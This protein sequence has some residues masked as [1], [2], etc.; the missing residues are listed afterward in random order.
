MPR[1]PNTPE[2]FWSKVNQTDTCWEW[3]GKSKPDGYVQFHLGG[4]FQYIHRIA[5]ELTH[6]PIGGGLFVLHKCDNRLCCN[7]AHLFLGTHQDNMDDMKN[8][9]RQAQG[10]THSRRIHEV[11]ARGERNG[12]SKLTIDDVREIRRLASSGMR[13]TDIARQFGVHK[14][15]VY[16]IVDQITWRHT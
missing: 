16:H 10:A 5:R 6:G 15:N 12:I 1:P 8:K 4:K 9:W 2:T 3:T 11:A 13:G 7:P 14:N